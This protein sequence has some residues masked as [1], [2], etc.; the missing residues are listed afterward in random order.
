MLGEDHSL[1]ADFPKFQT[2]IERL[3]KSDSTFLQDNKRYTALD[4]E[5]R[6]L[7]L[8]NAPI[9]DADI[10]LLKQERSVL[11]DALYQRLLKES[12]LQK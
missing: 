11:K 4:N 7:E 1:T 12:A 2:L 3:L 10:G 8:S 9:D 5:I 6:E